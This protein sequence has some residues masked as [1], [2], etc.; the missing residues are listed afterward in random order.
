MDLGTLDFPQIHVHLKD[1]ENPMLTVTLQG[2]FVSCTAIEIES[3]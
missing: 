1:K 3:Q 2:E